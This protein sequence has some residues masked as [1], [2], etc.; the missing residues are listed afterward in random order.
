VG[1]AIARL[2]G[3]W[4]VLC[5]ASTH[6]LHGPLVGLGPTLLNGSYHAWPTGH[7]VRPGHVMKLA[8]CWH[9]PLK[10]VSGRPYAMP[11]RLCF[12]AAHLNM[13]RMARFICVW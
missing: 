12:M 9:D 1:S 5:Y 13:T 3:H 4:A 6:G 7:E 8:S 10:I 11:T 2:V